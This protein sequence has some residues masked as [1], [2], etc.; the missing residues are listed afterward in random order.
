[1]IAYTGTFEVGLNTLD[2]VNR[3]VA[4]QQSI[5]QEEDRV[6][7]ETHMK[8]ISLL[9]ELREE[10]P[11][12]ASWTKPQILTALRAAKK[13]GDRANPK[14]RDELMS[15]W[16]ELRSRVLP[17]VV[18]EESQGNNGIGS[19]VLL[20]NDTSVPLV[21]VQV[22]QESFNGKEGANEQGAMAI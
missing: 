17:P 11:I 19:Q 9:N 6:K 3:R 21:P 10:K 4:V 18:E 20:A 1:M 12:E 7:Q 13:P 16:K 2:E 5:K 22:S 14:N 8:H 15:F